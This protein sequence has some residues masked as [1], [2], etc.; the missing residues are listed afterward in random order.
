MLVVASVATCLAVALIDTRPVIA[1]TARVSMSA[2]ASQVTVG[3][4]F[5]IEIRADVSG[6]EVDD[7]ELPDFGELEVLGRRVSRPF[8]VS[9]GFGSGGQ[10]ATVQ[11]QIVHSFT[12]R[13]TQPGSYTIQPAIVV[14]GPRRFASEP[15]RIEASGRAVPSNTPGM[16]PPASAGN[17]LNG[18]RNLALPPDGPLEGAAYDQD[19]FVR[20]VVDKSNAVV[21][22]QVTATVYLYV[23]GGL[24]NAPTVTKEPT[25]DGFW[26]QDLLP[27]NRSLSPS[28]QEVNGRGFNVYVLRRFAAFPL[29]PGTLQIAPTAI[30]IGGRPSLFDLLAGPS[31]ALRR[32]GIPVTV[33][34]SPLPERGDASRPAFVGEL[35][36]SA[37]VDRK[38]GRVGDAVTLRV[39]ARGLGNLKALT[40]P[41]PS[42]EGMDVLTPE[43]EDKVTMELDQVGGSREFRWLLLARKP[44][45]IPIPSTGVDVFDPATARYK[46]VAT[47]PIALTI[48]GS[49]APADAQAT[50]DQAPQDG[51]EQLDFGAIRMR[52]ALQRQQT[53]LHH[54]S[55][56]WL[57]V[58]GGPL[59]FVLA[60]ATAATRRRLGQAHAEK[61]GQ[62]AFKSAQAALEAAQAAAR[63]GDS[64]AA[65]AAIA[66]AIKAALEARLDE[67]VGGLTYPA[68]RQHLLTRGMPAPLS[69]RVV[70]QLEAGETSRFNPL[71]AGGAELDVA[72]EKS[73]GVIRELEKFAPTE[74]SS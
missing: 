32:T 73:R 17:G 23:R 48:T 59:L 69:D 26:V 3:E 46:H 57:A 41:D 55:W 11:S 18:N 31:S 19:A 44:G 42:V 65:H 62:R 74:A 37:E 60:R 63:G 1:Q 8:S 54:E 10:R 29:R 68:L 72:L 38:D 71:A 56:F 40:L 15:V 24:S 67:P 12:L 58:L 61:R 39:I 70:G 14:V 36:L 35:S 21:G 27:P 50:A 64:K 6:G 52:S 2:S 7:V 5:A 49:A 47:T 51:S 28:R 22:E 53:P 16:T 4:P 30:E 43:I 13:A 20:T 33:E 9:F 66:V 45:S 25:A 34:V